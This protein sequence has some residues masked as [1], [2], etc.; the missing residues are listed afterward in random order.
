MSKWTK[1]DL[2]DDGTE[3]L[4]GLSAEKINRT[5]AYQFLD[6]LK[7]RNQPEKDDPQDVGNKK[8]VFK[9]PTRSKGA[10]SDTVKNP[11][12]GLQ[13]ETEGSKEQKSDGS[14]VGGEG[15]KKTTSNKKDSGCGMTSG[16]DKQPKVRTKPSIVLSHLDEC[17]D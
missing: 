4:S 2:K 16:T 8:V 13:D 5:V 3:Q 9:K 11:A 1:Y 14:M 15:K 6:Q 7:Q 12:A 17:D 10:N